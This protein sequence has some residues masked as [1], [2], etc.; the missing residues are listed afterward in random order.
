MKFLK[1]TY[2]RTFSLFVQGTKNSERHHQE[3]IIDKLIIELQVKG[4]EIEKIHS[5]SSNHG[6]WIIIETKTDYK[7]LYQH[8]EIDDIINQTSSTMDHTH[9]QH[10]DINPHSLEIEFE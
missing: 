9:Q 8:F 1:K 6:L 3:R 5:N 4:F 7:N 10:N 2:I